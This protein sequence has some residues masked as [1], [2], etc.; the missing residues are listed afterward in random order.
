MNGK[1]VV[2]HSNGHGAVWFWF[3]N[4]LEEVDSP[5]EYYIDR[6]NG[7]LYLYEPEN[8]DTA[9]IVFSVKTKELVYGTNAN[10]ISFKNVAFTATRG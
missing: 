4:A 3:Y 1:E 5:G 7:I 8:F 6:E 9:S 2:D 10:Y